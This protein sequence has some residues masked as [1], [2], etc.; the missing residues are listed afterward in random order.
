MRIRDLQWKG[1]PAWPPEWW[2]TDQGG[3]ED[4]FLETVNIRKDPRLSC[5]SMMVNH[6]GSERRGIMVLEN[7]AHLDILYHK[8]KEN[9]GKPLR[10]IGNLEINFGFSVPRK[11]PKQV[12]PRTTPDID[13]KKSQ[14]NGA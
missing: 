8:L 6:L 12:R 9:I 5:I 3:G 14:L 7:L 4:G 13:N 2:T 1:I 11:G 10:E